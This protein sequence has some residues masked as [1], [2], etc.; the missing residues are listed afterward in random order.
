MMPSGGNP[1][2]AKGHRQASRAVVRS[3]TRENTSF[4]GSYISPSIQINL[5]R[6]AV[7]DAPHA[8]IAWAI[9]PTQILRALMLHQ[10]SLTSP[11]TDFTRQPS[12]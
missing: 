1:V 4:S 2:E 10:H 5:S 7:R 11:V 3:E 9:A 12:L 6:A 8:N